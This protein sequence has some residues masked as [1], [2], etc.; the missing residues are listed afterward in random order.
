MT[1]RR[2]LGEA[3]R[4]ALAMLKEGAGPAQA[5][6]GVVGRLVSGGLAT[7]I[8]LRSPYPSHRRHGRVKFVQDL[9]ITEAGELE[10]TAG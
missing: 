3:S 4:S 7:L 10:L 8:D 6:P 1:L 9:Q 2:P 5:N